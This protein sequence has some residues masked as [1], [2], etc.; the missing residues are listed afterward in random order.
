[1]GWSDA[2]SRCE[3]EGSHLASVLSPE[4]NQFLVDLDT[5]EG[6]VWL[7]GNDIATEGTWVWTDGLAWNYQNWYPSNPSNHGSNEHCA[8]IYFTKD[9][10]LWNDIHCSHLSAFICKKK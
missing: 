10:G 3:Q 7:G 2:Q 6:S 8:H 1:M 4:E 5:S 9:D